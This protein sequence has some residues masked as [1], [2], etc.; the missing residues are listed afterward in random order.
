[1]KFN[2][3]A[4]RIKGKYAEK[5]PDSC[6]RVKKYICLGY[7][8]T[9]DCYLSGENEAAECPSQASNDMFKITFNIALPEKFSYE[10]DELPE[11]MTMECWANVYLIATQDRHLYCDHRKIPYRKTTGDAEKIIKSAGKFF[12]RLYDLVMEDVKN[13]NVHEN[14]AALVAEKV[15]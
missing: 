1:M 3:F 15:R 4:E 2:E 13:G 11:N 5:F 6:C 10:S 7:S 8:I 12:D 14:Y 9:I